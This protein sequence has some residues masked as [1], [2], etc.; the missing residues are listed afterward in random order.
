MFQDL[1]KRAKEGEEEAI[2][3]ILEKL[4]PLIISSIRRNYNREAEYDD[5]IQMGYLK[6][7]ESIYEYDL[8]S[9]VYFLGFVKMN[10]RFMYLDCHK[11][12][13]HTSLNEP[14]KDQEDGFELLD[15]ILDPE[16][17]LEE[18]LSKMESE[19]ITN[20]LKNLPNRQKQVILM[21]YYYEMGIK[22]ISDSLNISYRT[23]VNTKTRALLNLRKSIGD[24]LF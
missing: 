23:V 5:L 14:C 21:Y 7:L 2:S 10:L 18:V 20:R 15:L 3:V 17:T 4:Y 8:S 13:I 22:E 16:D 24:G 11:R 19:Y 12:R 1:V 6:I 9:S